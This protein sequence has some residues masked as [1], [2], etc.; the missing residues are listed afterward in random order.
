MVTMVTEFHLYLFFHDL[1]ALPLRATYWA[2]CSNAC[3][4]LDFEDKCSVH[5]SK[6]VIC[7]NIKTKRC[8]SMRN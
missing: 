2:P 4:E 7:V 8:N 3:R 5:I 1:P 6:V